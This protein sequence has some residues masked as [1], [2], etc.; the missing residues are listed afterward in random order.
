M[1]VQW[2]SW[3]VIRA[4]VRSVGACPAAKRTRS[5]DDGVGRSQEEVRARW[6][7]VVEVQV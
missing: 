6:P 5:E 1:G 7:I 3:S 4:V 2:G